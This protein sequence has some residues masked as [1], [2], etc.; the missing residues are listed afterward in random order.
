MSDDRLVRA[1]V[2]VRSRAEAGARPWSEALT[3]AA[4]ALERE[5]LRVVR[6]GRFG[7]SVEGTPGEYAK[8]LGVES[9]T[10]GVHEVNPRD[11]ELSEL[12]D[13][14]EIA[15]APELFRSGG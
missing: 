8:A 12:A 7:I 9:L 14:L 5:G 10:T 6:V 4:G 3:S 2:R 1:T 15:G 11:A 13:V